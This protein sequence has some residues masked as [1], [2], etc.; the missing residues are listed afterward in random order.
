[1]TYLFLFRQQAYELKMRQMVEE[2]ILGQ[3]AVDSTM[4]P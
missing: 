1:M 3:H 4:R 2:I